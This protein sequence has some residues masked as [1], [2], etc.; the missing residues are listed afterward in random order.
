MFIIIVL[1]F[2][3]VIAVFLGC[4]AV[5]ETKSERQ[6]RA[7]LRKLERQLQSMRD[8]IKSGKGSGQ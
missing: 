8:R 2:A 4:V 3:F 6:E 7:E 5:A 1:A